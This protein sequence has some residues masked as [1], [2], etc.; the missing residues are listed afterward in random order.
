MP[1]RA[2]PR[3]PPFED[4][5]E[6]VADLSTQFNAADPVT[7][8]PMVLPEAARAEWTADELHMWYASGGMIAPPDNPKLRA[9]AAA[10]D[11]QGMKAAAQMERDEIL[12]RADEA[13]RKAPWLS[14][15]DERDRAKVKMYRDTAVAFGHPRRAVA[16]SDLYPADDPILVTCSKQAHMM[17]F[18][19]HILNWDE[20]SGQKKV[21]Y[22]EEGFTH[23][24]G[25]ALRGFDVRM[26]W[27]ASSL[28][29]V[30]AVRFSLGACICWQPD[31]GDKA[32]HMPDG[33]TSW[34]MRQ[35]H[36][37]CIEAVL[38]DLTAEV[39]K[40]NVAPRKQPA[41]AALTLC[42]HPLPSPSALT[43]SPSR[44]VPRDAS[45]QSLKPNT[46]QRMLPRR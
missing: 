30:G 13:A 14:K 28:K 2:P 45:N 8:E 19:K 33:S 42:P 24:A 38:D 40:I 31:G 20:V 3:T 43:L 32:T 4:F 10:M 37:G 39:M 22:G 7:N 21:V 23:G 35:V 44:N 11:R 34:A 26:Y 18:L 1:L 27:D 25:A 41:S 17:P 29:V 12:M 6:L 5:D 15:L 46:A 16:A 9:A 36:G